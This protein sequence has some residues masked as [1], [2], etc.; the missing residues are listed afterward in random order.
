MTD[1][2]I[3]KS[4][5]LICDPFYGYGQIIKDT[6]IKIGAKSVYY[7]EASF[8]SGSFRDKISIR[9]VLSWIR[10]P[11]RRSEWT[12]KLI[13]EIDGY[14]FDTFFVVE[15]MP[16]SLSFFDYLKGKN[17][18]IRSVLFLWD[19][20][21]TQQPRYS[22]FYVKF[23]TVYSFDRDDAKKYGLKYYPD[24]YIPEETVPISECVYDIAFVGSM[25]HGETKN[26]AKVLYEIYD[27]CQTNK[28]KYFI[29]LKHFKQGHTLLRRIYQ[30]L[31]DYSYVKIVKRYEK[32]GFLHDQ[33]L[34]IQQYNKVMA[35]TKVVVDL[36]YHQRQGMTINAITALAS[37]K[38][39]ITTNYRI[40]EEEFYNSSL[41]HVIGEKNPKLD[42]EF[43]K[44][45]YDPVDF[46][47]LR[48]DNW[49]RHIVNEQ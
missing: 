4:I 13:S 35:R 32:Y 37:G 24:F 3:G 31:Q 12:K 44:G 9:S 2:I 49:L 27:F 33:S 10:N 6:L 29:Y 8:Y 48:I 16:F 15:N 38:K 22:D 21:R 34:P 43:I 18:N 14:Q 30:L 19:T 40:K 17:S 11:K 1:N 41:I 26:R 46:S 42:V 45:P 25:T 20:I 36:S 7:K 39:L 47:H 23:D 28:L 5:L